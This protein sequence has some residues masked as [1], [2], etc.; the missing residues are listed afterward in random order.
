MTML[1][2]GIE[3]VDQ[4]RRM[5]NGWRVEKEDGGGKEAGFGVEI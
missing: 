4:H 2:V 3:E 1:A 5:R